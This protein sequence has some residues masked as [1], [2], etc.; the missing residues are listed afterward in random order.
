MPFQLRMYR[1]RPSEMDEWIQE[2]RE[3]VL[4]LRRAQGFSVIGPWVRREEDLFVW[5]VGHPELE[6]A[7]AAYYAS[8]ERR[9]LDPNPARHL[10]ETNSWIVAPLDEGRNVDDDAEGDQGEPEQQRR[11]EA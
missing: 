4:P 6:A 9:S 3:H 10:A 7:N 11:L 1:V 5:L 8:P 2:W